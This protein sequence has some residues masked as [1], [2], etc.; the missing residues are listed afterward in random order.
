MKKLLILTVEWPDGNGETF[1]EN[2]AVFSNGF[3]EIDCMPLYITENM[4]KVPKNIN[5]CP[6]EKKKNK[7]H[8]TTQ[9]IF[10]TFFVKELILLIKDGRFNFYNLKELIRFSM[11]A[12]YRYKSLKKWFSNN[13]YVN[14][15]TVYTYWMAS[16]A[17]AVAR[18]KKKGIKINL[19][20][21][22][23]HRFDL[24]EYATTG[25]Y[26][27][28]RKLI[29]DNVDKVFAISRDAI[30]YLENTYDSKYLSKYYLSRLGTLDYGLNPIK[31]KNIKKFRIVSCSN[32]I[33][34]KRVDIMISS[35]MKTEKEIEWIHFGD[36]ILR[37]E[38][39]KM[40]EV[41]PN[42]VSF[43]FMG[44][45]NNR[46][47]MTWYLENHVDL[48]VN[49][50]ESEGIPVSIMEA[51]SFGIPVL[52]T[53]VGGTGEIV[54]NGMNGVLVNKNIEAREL[55]IIIEELIEGRK[56]S[57]DDLR[58]NAREFWEIHYNA[59][60]NYSQFYTEFLQQK[61]K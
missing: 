47:L 27:P 29:L 10:N 26:I 31:N 44:R 43:T 30:N 39:S 52:A 37:D 61:G 23:C 54:Q 57:L 59:K 48:F 38:L 41:L 58:K 49:T 13:K 19:F 35:L 56:Y 60:V 9:G 22:R 14:N 24:Y 40:V 20:V 6:I 7:I 5:I 2:E 45:V 55:A 12:N 50:S 16:D 42:N 28:Y 4:R 21:T 3:D 53:N 34:V 25:K 17:M 46:N 32:L 51:M 15:I 36:G 18:L 8:D 11:I 33:K 1:F